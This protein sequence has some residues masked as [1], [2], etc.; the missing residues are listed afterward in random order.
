MKRVTAVLI[1]LSLLLFTAH[2]LAHDLVYSNT[3]KGV[4]LDQRAV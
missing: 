4:N 1:A 2:V 3:V